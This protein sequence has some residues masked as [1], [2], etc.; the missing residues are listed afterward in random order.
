MTTVLGCI[1][2]NVTS[3]FSTQPVK[4]T[5]SAKSI[6]SLVMVGLLRFLTV[7]LSLVSLKNVAA[8][9]TETVKSSAPFF[10]VIISRC[11]I[12][13]VTGL[14]VN[15]SL[16]PIML[17]LALCSAHELS[18]T[19]IGFAAALSTNVVECF[20]NVFSKKLMASYT[21]AELQF[22]ASLSAVIVQLPVSYL[23][24]QPDWRRSLGKDVLYPL[25][26]D[27]VC[28]HMQ[29]FTAYCLVDRITTVHFSV[30]NTVKRAL[31]IMVSV[32]LFGNQVTL[33]S[34]A[35]TGLVLIGVLSYSLA[36][37]RQKARNIV[38]VRHPESVLLQR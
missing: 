14:W 2:L 27:G 12:G 20:Q 25:L 36:S 23:L 31:I 33:L 15:L 38:F 6:W 4:A 24:V 28:F 8:S 18:F 16:L 34:G 32:L 30:C 5:R 35:G 13:E 26:L 29:S 21:C 1:Q 7:L 3:Y 17:G 22:Y 9:F 10:T 19:L 37:Q 11:L